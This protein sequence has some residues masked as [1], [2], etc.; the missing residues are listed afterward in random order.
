MKQ[1]RAGFSGF[2]SKGKIFIFGG[3]GKDDKF[4]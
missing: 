3:I 2:V 1:P 4:F